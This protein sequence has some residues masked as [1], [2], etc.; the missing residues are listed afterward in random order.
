MNFHLSL[1]LHFIFTKATQIRG[2][3]MESNRDTQSN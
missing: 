2:R 3:L 1:F